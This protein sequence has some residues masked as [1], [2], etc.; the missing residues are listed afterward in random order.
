MDDDLGA[1]VGHDD[2]TPSLGGLLPRRVA[3]DHHHAGEENRPEPQS[4]SVDSKS[5]SPL[6]R[7]SSIMVPGRAM[8]VESETRTPCVPSSL[9][10]GALMANPRSRVSVVPKSFRLEA[11]K[12]IIFR[13]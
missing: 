5:R 12:V 2:G 4:R 1:Q 13:E 11:Q 10:A 8:N 3:A 6:R 9:E 7:S